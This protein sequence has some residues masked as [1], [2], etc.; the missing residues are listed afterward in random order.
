[1]V[2]AARRTGMRDAGSQSEESGL[3]H[4]RLRAVP[5]GLRT[6]LCRC[7][8]GHRGPPRASR[9]TQ[10]GGPGQMVAGEEGAERTA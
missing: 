5:R 10:A 6:G 1:M 9:R 8:L 2:Q 7:A 4:M 3:A